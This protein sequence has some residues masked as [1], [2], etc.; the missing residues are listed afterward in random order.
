MR[1]LVRRACVGDLPTVGTVSVTGPAN[2][3]E[4]A[5]WRPDFGVLAAGYRVS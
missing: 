4:D 5:G 1:L 3:D 2:P